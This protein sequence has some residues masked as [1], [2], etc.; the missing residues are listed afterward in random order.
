MWAVQVVVPDDPRHA[1]PCRIARLRQQ[2]EGFVQPFD[3]RG[4]QARRFARQ[5]IGNGVCGHFGL[6]A[7]FKRVE[8]DN[9]RHQGPKQNGKDNDQFYSCAAAVAGPCGLRSGQNAAQSHWHSCPSRTSGLF[10]DHLMPCPMDDP[11]I[12][13]RRQEGSVTHHYI[14]QPRYSCELPMSMSGPGSSRPSR[15]VRS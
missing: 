10:F 11:T 5:S 13:Y 8:K 6:I 15:P 2:I 7:R 4:I 9:C 12:A 14:L 3:I 1:K